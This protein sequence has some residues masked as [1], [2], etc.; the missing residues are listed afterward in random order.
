MSEE[1]AKAMLESLKRNKEV[2]TQFYTKIKG[3]D[4]KKDTWQLNEIGLL[5]ACKLL[6]SLKLQASYITQVFLTGGKPTVTTKMLSGLAIK[7]GQ[8]KDIS[9][10]LFDEKSLKICEENK[11]LV[12]PP[13]GAYCKVTR[14]E[15]TEFFKL[16]TKE[17][18]KK[19][20]LSEKKVWQQYTGDMLAHKARTR[21]LNAAFPELCIE[22]SLNE[23]F[24]G[25][26]AI[27]EE[28]ATIE[29][30]TVSD[31]EVKPEEVQK[32]EDIM[33]KPEDK[34]YM[35]TIPAHMHEDF[36]QKVKMFRGLEKECKELGIMSKDKVIE[37]EK[38]AKD[39]PYSLNEAIRTLQ[40]KIG[41][42]NK[43]TAGGNNA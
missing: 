42:H 25:D 12:N 29:N 30:V 17:D 19:A 11:N 26:D 21:A 23:N 18:A 24:T 35:E 9:E 2:P 4:G 22:L 38:L 34:S 10:Y 14:K 27:D 16:F 13:F 6:V 39:F 28:E 1:K 8:I 20:G 7:T 31:L 33:D 41:N 40:T 15:G 43:K 37:E 32:V 36:H 3:K 5:K